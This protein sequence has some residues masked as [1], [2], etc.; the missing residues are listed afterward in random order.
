MLAAAVAEHSGPPADSAEPTSGLERR[1][2]KRKTLGKKKVDTL[3]VCERQ[4]EAF[5]SAIYVSKFM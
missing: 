3:Y 1:L 5:R 4:E 2:L